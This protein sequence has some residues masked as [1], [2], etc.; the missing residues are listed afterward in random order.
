MIEKNLTITNEMGMHARPASQFVALI[1]G[2]K[3]DIQIIKGTRTANAK[4]IINVLS[5][6]LV[7]GAEI[8][9]RT[10]GM[11]EVEAMNTIENFIVALKD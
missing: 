2:F 11:D 10:N 4:S 5:L 7:Q 9:V 6:A 8:I 1:N 3:S